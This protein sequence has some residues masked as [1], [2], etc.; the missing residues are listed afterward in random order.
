MSL[1]SLSKVFLKLLPILVV[2]AFC[3]VAGGTNWLTGRLHTLFVDQ[4]RASVVQMLP[5]VLNLAISF[6]VVYAAFLLFQPAR[7][8][9]DRCLNT[10]GGNL[11][12]RG[13]RFWILSFQ[14]VFWLTVL[15]SAVRIVAPSFVDSALLGGGIFMGVTVLAAQDAVKNI[16]A[17]G[18]LHTMPNC[19]EGDYVKIAGPDGA[20]GV[21][22]KV[23]YLSTTIHLKGSGPCKMVLPNS[24]VWNN[25]VIVG[26]PEI[27][28]KPKKVCRFCCCHGE[29]KANS[30]CCGC[31]GSDAREGSKETDT[32]ADAEKLSEGRGPRSAHADGGSPPA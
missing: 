4:F 27:E 31:S 5:V 8:A 18:F 20:E 22:T 14:A 1:R 11:S 7:C 9:L 32:V 10:T 28:E 30:D 21:I 25:A 29:E 6:C 13:K 17:S 23:D 3:I 16:I 12:A 15:A 19:Q 24:V 26:K 2:V